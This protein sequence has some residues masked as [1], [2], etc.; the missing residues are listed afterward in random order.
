MHRGTC[1]CEGLPM[2]P[3]HRPCRLSE[4]ACAHSHWGAVH[5]RP[6]PPFSQHL[7]T[8]AVREVSGTPPHPQVVCVTPRT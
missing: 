6:P 4:T 2:H 8:L 3:L 5:W 7:H 1:V